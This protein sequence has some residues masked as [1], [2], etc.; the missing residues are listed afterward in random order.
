MLSFEEAL[1]VEA[2]ELKHYPNLLAAQNR[3]SSTSCTTIYSAA[4]CNLP[5]AARS[6]IR[7]RAAEEIEEH[8]H[9]A[10]RKAF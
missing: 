3:I 4:A 7:L 2:S 6:P 9:A 1:A 8:T 10:C 5:A